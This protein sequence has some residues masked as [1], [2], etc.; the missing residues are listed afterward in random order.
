MT[1]GKESGYTGRN[2]AHLE[3]TLLIWR[4]GAEWGHWTSSTFD[5]SIM[6]TFLWE[7]WGVQCSLMPV[8]SQFVYLPYSN[9]MLTTHLLGDLLTYHVSSRDPAMTIR[10]S[11]FI[12]VIFCS[13]Q[14]G[15]WLLSLFCYV[16]VVWFPWSLNLRILCADYSSTNFLIPFHVTQS[17]SKNTYHCP[18]GSIFFCFFKLSA[19]IKA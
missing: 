1:I 4:W 7:C 5:V 10:V 17:F 11:D 19:L 16:F 18:I 6:P 3:P 14:H 13:K 9:P 15:L 8:S 12:R 2:V